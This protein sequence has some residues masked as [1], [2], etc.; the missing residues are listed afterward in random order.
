MTKNIYNISPG[1]T[2]TKG[3]CM[4]GMPSGLWAK[5]ELRQNHQ[6]HSTQSSQICTI[7]GGYCYTPQRN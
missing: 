5:L 7:C 4:P 3:V 1:G 6:G 2:I